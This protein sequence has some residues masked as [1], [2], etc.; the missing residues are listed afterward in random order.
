DALEVLDFGGVHVGQEIVSCG[1]GRLERRVGFRDTD[2]DLRE[3]LAHSH[4]T[5]N[6]PRAYARAW[7]VA[8]CHDAVTLW[9]ASGQ[10]EPGRSALGRAS[11]VVRGSRA[12]TGPS[13]THPSSG[14]KRARVDVIDP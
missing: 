12:P 2:I 1:P 11:R 7:S 5:R 14:P 8:C 13:H 3:E 4:L 9:I 10:V 6:I